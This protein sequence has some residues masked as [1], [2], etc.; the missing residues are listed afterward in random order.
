MS[1]DTSSDPVQTEPATVKAPWGPLYAI[2]GSLFAFLGAQ[3]IAQVAISVYIQ[4]SGWSKSHVEY[5]FNHTVIA[6]FWSILVSEMAIVGFLWILVMRYPRELWQKGIGLRHL[7]WRDLGFTLIGVLAYF[8]VYS[9]VLSV[10]SHFVHVNTGQTQELGFDHVAGTTSLVLTFVSLVVLPPIVEEIVFRGFLYGGLRRRLH[11]VPAAL[12]A[13]VAFAIPHAAESSH[14]ILWIAA[15][16]TFSLSLV[17]CYLREK[18]G[19]VYAGIGLHAIKNA[20]AFVSL[21]ILHLR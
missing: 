15:I 10:I 8:G 18:T 21:F 7:K 6:Q 4:L 12:I 9:L 14:G 19:A 2:F 20:I 17:L 5:T 1:N 13:S 3:Y 16:D 11:V